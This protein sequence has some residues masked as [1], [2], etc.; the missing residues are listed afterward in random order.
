MRDII[1]RMFMKKN[2]SVYMCLNKYFNESFEHLIMDGLIERR[3]V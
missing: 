2:L 1:E 3:L